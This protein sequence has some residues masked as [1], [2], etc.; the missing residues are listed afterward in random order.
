[1][2][3]GRPRNPDI[4]VAIR[5]A[6]LD[7]VAEQGYRGVSIEG[8]AARSGV[9]KQTVY[10]RFSGRGELILDALT[11]DAADRLPPRAVGTLYEDLT[12]FLTSTFAELNGRGGPLNRALLVEVLQDREFAD[13]F[14]TRHIA[15]RRAAVAEILARARARGEVES[16]DDETLIDLV[17]GPMWYRLLIG[18]GSLDA[19]YAAVL[20]R[21]V[22]TVAALDG[23]G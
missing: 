6:T 11:A 22:V 15:A 13:L 17:F 7:L 8:I 12:S 3:Q 14:R 1:M 2:V 21:A 16:D 20:A 9:A 4:D 18:H 19:G 10:R 23:A 5:E